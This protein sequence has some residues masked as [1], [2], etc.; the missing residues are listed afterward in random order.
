V[1]A[2]V[3]T[4]AAS[5]QSVYPSGAVSADH[6]VASRAGARMLREGG[7]A[8]DAAVAAAFTLSVVRPYSCGIGGGG[9][10]IVHMTDDPRQAGSGPIR[11][12]FNYRESA[13]AWVGPDTFADDP[14]PLAPT[15]GGRSVCV[16]GTV[17]GLLAAHERFGLLPRE[18]VLAP[19]IEA[20]QA[21][22][23]VDEHYLTSVREDVLPIFE[24]HADARLRFAFVWER[25]LLEGRV[26]QGDTIR[27]PEQ[28]EALRLIARDGAP[29][30]YA[31]AIADAIIRSAN[32][33]GAR[34]TM[35]DLAGFTVLQTA[36]VESHYRR[37]TMLGMPPP[38]SGGVA[39][40]QALEFL[41]RRPELAR[42]EHNSPAYAHLVIEAL[43]HAFADRARWMGDPAFVD[44]PVSRLLD[45]LYMDELAERFDPAR[46]LPGASY[47]SSPPGEDAPD[48]AGTSHLC[49]VDRWGNA[50]ACTETINLIF[51]SLVAVE[52]FG[53]VLNDTMDDFTA[54]P[55]RPN[56]FG[57]VQSRRNAIAPGKRALSSMSP[58]IVLEDGRVAV[59]AGAAG[60]PRIIS[61]TLQATLNVLR[62]DM[63]ASAA[64]A[65]PR[66]HHQWRPDV[67]WIERALADGP[68]PDALRA[69][70]H[71][72]RPRGPIGN[73]QIIR[74]AT[75]GWDAA[76]DP[77]K[78]GVPDGH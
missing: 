14:D 72:V 6:A 29:A 75:G 2:I 66:F 48:D 7:N 30:F 3:L 73:V 62:F 23:A 61:S 56:E 31:G 24:R 47:G 60:G 25:F 76:A 15:R 59:V 9:F 33:D 10:M 20:A 65:A 40:A 17:A 63:P 32:A 78:G 44:V 11:V 4:G 37:W 28:A 36:P 53:F 50:V 49:A 67:L 39:M 52:G 19:A 43:K 46:T 38:S 16:P 68:L 74:R 71:D 22:F 5:G 35:Q 77:R 8:V 12:A 41:E 51:G 13:P 69:L 26:R 34:L 1:L 27:L 57:L 64:L 58:T 42:A 21:G 70:G 54:R 55:G 18:R 45:E